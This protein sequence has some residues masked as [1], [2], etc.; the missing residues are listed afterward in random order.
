MY[1]A[2]VHLAQPINDYHVCANECLKCGKPLLSARQ[3]FVAFFSCSESWCVPTLRM[4]SMESMDRV[5]ESC[6][7]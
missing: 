3:P 6:K 4:E 1:I 2:C 5:R 7:V